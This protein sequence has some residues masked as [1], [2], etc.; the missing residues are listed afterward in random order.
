M[1][2]QHILFLSHSHAF[3]AFRVGS[4]HYARALAAG[5]DTVVHLS[6]P[7]SIAHRL[8]RRVSADD[9]AQVP[10]TATPDETGVIHVVPRTIVPAPYGRSA[11]KRTLATMGLP[12]RYDAVL[13]DQPL[14]W[15]DSIRELT[16]R[17]IYRPTDLYPDGV[18]HDLQM[19]ILAAADGVVAT[20]AEVL[21]SLGDVRVPSLVIENGV[22]AKAFALAESGNRAPSAVYVGALDS[23]FDWTQLMAWAR[24]FSTVRFAVAGPLGPTPHDV[25]EN[26]ELL[27]T[28]PYSELPVLLGSARVGLLPLSDD[29]LNRGR[30]PMK[31]YEYLSAGLSVVARETPVIGEDRASGIFT[32]SH[33]AGARV[34]LEQA[35]AAASPN[36]S[37][38]I[39]AR[40]ES[41]TTK[42]STLRA[43]ALGL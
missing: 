24:Q 11:V 19:R 29:P 34:A 2:S 20:S 25:P 39:R 35:L 33:P 31:L 12:V 37:G 8:L 1:S 21:R 5:G 36:V 16:D 26:V 7:I 32:Y 15:D 4:H 9:L 10:R 43:F 38:S 22:D 6:T 14:L 42:A 27:G 3:G 17:L 30:S 40:A 18:K 41:W 28:V 13:L 23:R